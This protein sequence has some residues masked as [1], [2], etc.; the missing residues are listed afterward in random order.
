MIKHKKHDVE[1]LDCVLLGD[2]TFPVKHFVNENVTR[3]ILNPAT[4]IESTIEVEINV[5]LVKKVGK[6]L[7]DIAG[8]VARE[9]STFLKS[10]ESINLK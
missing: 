10:L 8:T 6:E 1:N 4:E 5:H 3:F 7:D 9:E 2:V